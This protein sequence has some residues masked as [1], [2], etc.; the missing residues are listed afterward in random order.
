MNK[1]D[2]DPMEKEA[3]RARIQALKLPACER[4]LESNREEL[5]PL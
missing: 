3:F 5:V 2:D 1:L 4:I